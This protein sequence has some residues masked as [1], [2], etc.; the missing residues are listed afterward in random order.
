VLGAEML[1][2]DPIGY[3]PDDAT[4]GDSDAELLRTQMAPFW[5]LFKPGV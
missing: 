1:L 2:A 3:L 5:Q 4:R